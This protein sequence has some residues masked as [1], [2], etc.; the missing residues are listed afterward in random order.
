MF[1]PAYRRARHKLSS[2]FPSRIKHIAKLLTPGVRTVQLMPYIADT[3][4]FRAERRDPQ[5]SQASVSSA[6]NAPHQET[7]AECFRVDQSFW[8]QMG[9]AIPHGAAIALSRR[10]IFEDMDRD[11]KRPQ[12][13]HVRGTDA[14]RHTESTARTQLSTTLTFISVGPLRPTS[15]DRACSARPRK[16]LRMALDNT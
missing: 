11:A 7:Q 5:N 10:A 6:V 1:C 3:R 9:W 16:S 15:T 13:N 14:D 4:R 8:I 2:A 12:G